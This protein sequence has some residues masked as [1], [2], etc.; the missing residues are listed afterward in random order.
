M[1]TVVYEPAYIDSNAL[2]NFLANDI[3]GRGGL[4]R[5]ST[6]ALCTQVYYILE[7]ERLYD[8]VDIYLLTRHFLIIDCYKT[9]SIII[10]T[11]TFSYMYLFVSI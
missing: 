10:K 11:S 9:A 3:Y 1:G 8:V 7:L 4:T 6:S 5:S 2:L